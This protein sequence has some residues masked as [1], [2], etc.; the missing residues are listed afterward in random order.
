MKLLQLD[1]HEMAGIT[2]CLEGLKKDGYKLAIGTSQVD[3]YTTLALIKLFSF[4]Q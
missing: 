3:L 2:V 4:P 1:L